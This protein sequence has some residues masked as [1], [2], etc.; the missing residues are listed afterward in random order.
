MN[1]MLSP[2]SPIQL[3]RLQGQQIP[4]FR[5]IG[6]HSQT[7]QPRQPVT[8]TQVSAPQEVDLNLR[9]PQRADCEVEGSKKFG[10]DVWLDTYQEVL[11]TADALA[12]TSCHLAN[13]VYKV[14][15][16]VGYVVSKALYH[17]VMR[18]VI[19]ITLSS[20]ILSIL[21]STKTQRNKEKMSPEEDKHVLYQQQIKTKEQT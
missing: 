15:K 11:K 8:L 2:A 4:W 21:E 10:K 6:T 20:T 9:P 18:L 16:W 17:S 7:K 13:K 5:A 1:G 3:E 14:L 19:D 12:C